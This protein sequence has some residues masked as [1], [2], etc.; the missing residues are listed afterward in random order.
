MATMR[1]VA[2]LAG[3]SR[4][5]VSNV[6][7]GRAG[8]SMTDA[9][10]QRVIAAIE[11][12]DYHPDVNAARLRSRRARTIMFNVLDPSPRFLADAFTVEVLAGAAEV[13]RRAGYDLL[14]QGGDVAS[15]DHLVRVVAPLLQRRADGLILLPSGSEPDWAE[16]I[17]VV[18]RS[19]CPLVIFQGGEWPEPSPSGA[20][21]VSADD[22]GGGRACGDLLAEL[23]HRRVVFVTTAVT[24]PAVERRRAGLSEALAEH[25][26]PAPTTVIS[27]DWS[28]AQTHEAVARY[29]A[30]LAPGDQPTAIMGA[31]DVLAA[32]VL[33]AARELVIDVPGTL[34][35]IGFDDLDIAGATS[36]SL[37]TVKVPGLEM[38]R[39]AAQTLLTHIH[40]TGDGHDDRR[41]DVELIRRGSTAPAG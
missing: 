3:V 26:I 24:W 18:S 38:G 5:T 20:I 23:G 12:L 31:N 8:H 25:G 37:T 27:S 39:Y 2:D 30:A 9:T 4:Q 10:R 28:V 19:G 32:G 21:N 7:N 16:T 17:E 33:A 34:S 22:Y 35:V 15:P 6:I 13:L 14:L 29:L 41:F 36:P 1:E 11:A 40:G